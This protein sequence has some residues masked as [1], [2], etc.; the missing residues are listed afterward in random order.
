MK[1]ENSILDLIFLRRKF[2]LHRKKTA[3]AGSLYLDGPVHC[4]FHRDCAS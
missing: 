4:E 2:E 1:K 3:E